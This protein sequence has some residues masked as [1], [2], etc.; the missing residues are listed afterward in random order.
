MEYRAYYCSPND[1]FMHETRTII[2]SLYL[3]EHQSLLPR[4]ASPF[5]CLSRR[6]T[7]WSREKPKQ[8]KTFN[9]IL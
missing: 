3:D 6:R 4:F 9:S 7:Q 5:A 1:N 2:E 8:P